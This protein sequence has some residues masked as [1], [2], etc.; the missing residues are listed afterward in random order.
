[1]S[2]IHLTSTIHLS[3]LKKQFISIRMA[4]SFLYF[5]LLLID[6]IL[7]IRKFNGLLIQTNYTVLRKPWTFKENRFFKILNGIFEWSKGRKAKQCIPFWN[8]LNID[9]S[10]EWQCVTV[11]SSTSINWFRAKW[12]LLNNW[13]MLSSWQC[14]IYKSLRTKNCIILLMNLIGFPFKIFVGYSSFRNSSL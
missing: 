10:A 8:N 14:S 2:F 5:I 13:F 3:V 12:K 11:V 4:E 1:M 9:F 7:L 6:P